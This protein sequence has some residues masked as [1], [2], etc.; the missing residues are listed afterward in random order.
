MTQ[1]EQQKVWRDFIDALPYKKHS[2][3]R[4]YF[5]GSL[6]AVL[7]VK[8]ISDAV[9]HCRKLMAEDEHREKERKEK[10]A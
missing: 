9:E 8:Q 2:T 3:A 5:I 10:A 1:S 7:S 4:S 6:L